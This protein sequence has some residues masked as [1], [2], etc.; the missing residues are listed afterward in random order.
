MPWLLIKQLSGLVQNLIK[1]R[2]LIVCSGMLE[3]I[4]TRIVTNRIVYMSMINHQL[5]YFTI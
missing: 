5:P 2:F 3:L 4:H 1:A